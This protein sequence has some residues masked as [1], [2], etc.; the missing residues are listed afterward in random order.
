MAMRI[1][2]R[3]L[4]GGVH[5]CEGG[6]AGEKQRGKIFYARDFDGA[7]VFCVRVRRLFGLVCRW[8]IVSGRVT[9]SL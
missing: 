2:A 4:V 5:R 6:R 3:P 8:L 1:E 7:E 9:R